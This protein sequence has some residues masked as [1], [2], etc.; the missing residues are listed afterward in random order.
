ME[1][2]LSSD[3]GIDQDIKSLY[4]RIFD[5]ILSNNFNA[6]IGDAIDCLRLRT[7][8]KTYRGDSNFNQKYFQALANLFS[9]I[10]M[11]SEKNNRR[12][13]KKLSFDPEQIKL[14][15]CILLEYGFLNEYFNSNWQMLAEGQFS[16]FLGKEQIEGLVNWISAYVDLLNFRN[17]LIDPSKYAN[18]SHKIVPENFR[19]IVFNQSI[20]KQLFARN[21]E[22]LVSLLPHF[23]TIFIIQFGFKSDDAKIENEFIL[24]VYCLCLLQRDLLNKEKNFELDCFKQAA[25]FT[26]GKVVDFVSHIELIKHCK[27]D[28]DPCLPWSQIQAFATS[29][30]LLDSNKALELFLLF[31]RLRQFFE[32]DEASIKNYLAAIYLYYPETVALWVKN[33]LSQCNSMLVGIKDQVATKVQQETTGYNNIPSEN[34]EHYQTLSVDEEG[35]YKKQALEVLKKIYS[36]Y[37]FAF[38]QDMAQKDEIKAIYEGNLVLF[39]AEVIEEHKKFLADQLVRLGR[40]AGVV[41]PDKAIKGEREVKSEISD[42]EKGE[43]TR[44]SSFKN[45]TDKLLFWKDRSSMTK[46]GSLNAGTLRK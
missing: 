42:K 29:P 24:H 32:E 21:P 44:R 5:K 38:Q 25:A 33:I 34:S 39:P 22:A 7:L 1:E 26:K 8:L 28:Q 40:E 20:C 10:F 46:N 4:G 13:S 41:E 30:L 43:I 27:L 15:F 19:A 14:L 2:L 37:A 17:S 3:L 18:H 31:Y 36:L 11:S 45:F 23:F 6:A 16:K 9:T 35:F 12:K